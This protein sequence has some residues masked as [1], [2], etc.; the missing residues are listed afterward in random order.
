MKVDVTVQNNQTITAA[1]NLAS[2]SRVDVTVGIWNEQ[3]QVN[4]GTP[5]DSTVIQ[6]TDTDSVTVTFDVDTN[7]VTQNRV[8]LG[9]KIEAPITGGE[10]GDEAEFFFPVEEELGALYLFPINFDG[11]KTN[12]SYL[13]KDNTYNNYFEGDLA[14]LSLNAPEKTLVGGG[15]C[16][17]VPTGSDWS[18]IPQLFAGFQYCPPTGSPNKIVTPLTPLPSIGHNRITT[19]IEETLRIPLNLAE[20]TN[21]FFDRVNAYPNLRLNVTLVP[22]LGGTSFNG[23]IKYSDA[24]EIYVHEAKFLNKDEAVVTLRVERPTVNGQ[25]LDTI[26]AFSDISS[27]NMRMLWA[28]FLLNAEV[29]VQNPTTQEFSVYSPRINQDGYLFALQAEVGAPESDQ[30]DDA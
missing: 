16:N 11:G 13:R 28:W 15:N 1:Q 7:V 27:Q 6:F 12:T 24:M 14:N 17:I 4:V 19:Y 25:T 23:G 8:W 30:F 2:P 3:N 5:L 10:F 29:E 18:Q 26:N 9:Y 20:D 21:Q 22:G